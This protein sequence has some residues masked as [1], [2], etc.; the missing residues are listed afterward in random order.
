MA[1][2]IDEKG[3]RTKNSSDRQDMK[4]GKCPPGFK[5]DSVKQECVQKGVGPQ[6]R[7]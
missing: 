3:R 7:P 6:Y 5:W 4:K 2:T 1:Y